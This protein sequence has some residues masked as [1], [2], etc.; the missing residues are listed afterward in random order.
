MIKIEPG[1][2]PDFLRSDRVNGARRAAEEFYRGHKAKRA[3]TRHEFDRDIFYHPDLLGALHA[4]FYSKC[5]FCESPPEVVGDLVCGHYRPYDGAVDLAGNFDPDAYW[6]LAYEWEN[7][8]LICEA[9]WK[10]KGNRFPIEASARARPGTVGDALARERPVL[11]DPRRDQPEDL[12]VYDPKGSIAAAQTRGMQSI[13]ILRLDRGELRKAR[14]QAYADL[15]ARLD[16]MG[17]PDGVPESTV[18]SLLDKTVPYAGLRRYV[19]LRWLEEVS[20][21]EPESEVWKQ[22][23]QDADL[24]FPDQAS[25]FD[26][27]ASKT[28]AT[29]EHFSKYRSAVESSLGL[30]SQGAASE[31][32]FLTSRMIERIEIKNF[33]VVRDLD[34]DLTSSDATRGSWLTLLGENGTGKSSI[35]Q[36]IALALLGNEYRDSLGVDASE[37]VTH[38]ERSGSVRIWLSARDD[39][40]ELHF[41]STG[42]GFQGGPAEPATLLLAYGSTRLL[43]RPGTEPAPGRVYAR[44]D[45]LFNP[46]VPL[47]DADEWLLGL[48]QGD[49]NSV[50]S[51]IKRMMDLRG[52]ARF[53]R[54][55][56]KGQRHVVVD[57][58]GDRIPLSRLSDGYQSV[59]AL[60]ADVMAVMSERWSDMAVAEGL[61]LIDELGAHLHPEW[62]MR[63][64][65]ALREAFPRVQFITTTHSPLCLRGLEDGE[66]VVMKRD[67]EDHVFAF[68]DLPPVKGLRVDQLLLSDHF[69]LLGGTADPAIA[70]TFDEYY[71]LLA[72]EHPTDTQRKRI[73]ELQASLPIT[74]LAGEL[75]RDRM[76]YDAIDRYLARRADDLRAS[77]TDTMKP[78][79]VRKL[80]EIL[81]RR[82][83]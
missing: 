32:Y 76:M 43:P 10:S 69:G 62:Q 35:L 45:N 20:P 82:S 58:F 66:V 56:R 36:A 65:T 11:I 14:H 50:A 29:Q 8:Y 40:V 16:D 57:A 3:Q 9:C 38:G 49:F 6:W 7:L 42:S 37:L 83:D 71:A 4:T 60:A 53:R 5:A 55:T 77:G 18:P 23:A 72:V 24:P 41:S 78:R 73:A 15:Q 75:P 22:A 44:V 39:P 54:I 21:P 80:N 25:G 28:E 48:G 12:F 33:T 30:D 27:L 34:L 31:G 1:S 61:V 47:R 70:R 19:L 74:G 63:I 13:E 81:D 59:V 26:S 79:L 17:T 67:S 64:V 68:T 46:F 2:A 52:D 51:A